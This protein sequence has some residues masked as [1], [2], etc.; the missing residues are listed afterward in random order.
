MLQAYAFLGILIVFSSQFMFFL[1]MYTRADLGPQ[2]I[3][4]SFG[5]WEKF[6]DRSPILT[7]TSIPVNSTITPHFVKS[8][9]V[10]R[11]GLTI[12][13]HY[14]RGQT[15]TFITIIIL[16]VFGNLYSTRTNIKSFFLHS[17]WR[18]K[19]RN[20]WL[21]PAQIISIIIMI[22][23]VFIPPINDLFNSRQ[24]PVH[25]FF[26]PLGFALIIFTCDEIRKLLVRKNILCFKRIG[27]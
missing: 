22:L 9:Q 2:D 18:K 5:E 16:Q 19:S 11:N 27:W 13:E 1:Y 24:V 12:E 17:P 10:L 4:L 25:F 21:F 26:I 14:F 23:V 3:F 15:V 6:A 20:F 7:T 8:D